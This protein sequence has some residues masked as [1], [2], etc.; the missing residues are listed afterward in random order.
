M[1]GG[2]AGAAATA[3]TDSIIRADAMCGSTGYG[4]GVARGVAG[5][6][7]TGRRRRWESAGSWWP[8][9]DAK[10]GAAHVSARSASATAAAAAPDAYRRGSRSSSRSARASSARARVPGARTFGPTR[11]IKRPL[12]TGRPSSIGSSVRAARARVRFG[13]TVEEVPAVAPSGTASGVRKTARIV[14]RP[15]PRAPE[16]PARGGTFVV[17]SQRSFFAQQYHYQSFFYV[18]SKVKV[19][20]KFVA[21][22]SELVCAFCSDCPPVP[23]FVCD[24]SFT[25]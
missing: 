15:S 3:A 17:M 14:A 7:V 18:P 22:T 8:R 6:C 20:G 25:T 23:N 21:F 5:G 24:T 4:L 9:G 11:R 1:T 13:T 19:F 10:A 12:R 2:G 16:S